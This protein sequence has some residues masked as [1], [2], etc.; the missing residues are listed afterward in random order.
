MTERGEN[1][2][3]RRIASSVRGASP[4]I[5]RDAVKQKIPRR[6]EGGVSAYFKG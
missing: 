1:I 5:S 4:W 6:D 2:E 3:T